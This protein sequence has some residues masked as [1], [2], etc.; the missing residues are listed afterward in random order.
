MGH[1][2]RVLIWDEAK[3]HGLSP[4]QVHLLLRLAVEPPARR[5]VSALASEL[6]VRPPTVSDAVAT[7]RR[8]DLVGGEDA[9][10]DRRGRR[11]ELTDAGMRVAKELTGWPDG[12][13]ALLVD[14]DPGTKAATLALLL[15]LI[16]GLQRRGVI[17]VA[18]TCTTCRHFARDAHPAELLRHRC[19]LLDEPLGEAELR[20]D[21]AEHERLT[22]A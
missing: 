4:M 19:R 20:V 2:L 10:E 14:V 15:D 16:G 17:S 11:L 3:R 12:V 5:R 22:A 6:D 21:C 8:K 1:A 9:P 18:R 13:H 7:L